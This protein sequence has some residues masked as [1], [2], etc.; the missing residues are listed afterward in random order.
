MRFNSAERRNR[1]FSEA[2]Y[3][4]RRDFCDSQVRVIA[5]GIT[6]VITNKNRFSIERYYFMSAY[7]LSIIKIL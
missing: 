3:A 5:D 2:F 6:N 4:L 1:D 7:L